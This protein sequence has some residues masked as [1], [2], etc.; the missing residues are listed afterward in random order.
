MCLETLLVSFCSFCSITT[1]LQLDVIGRVTGWADL[2]LIVDSCRQFF[3]SA[4]GYKRN[5]LP[6]AGLI[7][8]LTNSHCLVFPLMFLIYLHLLILPEHFPDPLPPGRNL[9]HSCKPVCNHCFSTSQQYSQIILKP[10][11]SLLTDSCMWIRPLTKTM[12]KIFSRI[13]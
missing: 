6:A 11:L 3:P 8:S 12:A 7:P 1:C 2:R 10:F 13:H 4:N 9:D 5:L